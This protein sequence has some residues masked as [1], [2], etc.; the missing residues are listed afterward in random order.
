M[1]F[2][3]T[4]NTKKSQ[5]TQK[6][7]PFCATCDTP[8][9]GGFVKLLGNKSHHQIMKKLLL[10]LFIF[11]VIEGNAQNKLSFNNVDKN[12]YDYYNSGDWQSLI[13]IGEEAIKN[14]IDY[15][16]LN[17]RMGVANYMMKNYLLSLHYFEKAIYQNNTGL[18]DTIL[19]RLLMQDYIFTNNYTKAEYLK[20]YH[21]DSEIRTM[22]FTKKLSQIYLEGGISI[23]DNITQKV[24]EER[25]FYTFKQ[26]DQFRTMKYVNADIQGYIKQNLSYQFAFSGLQIDRYKFFK[27]FQDTLEQNYTINQSYIYGGI[28]YSLGN[29]YINPAINLPGYLSNELSIIGQDSITL[30]NIYDTVKVNKR[31]LVGGLRFGMKY[32]R[33]QVG[34]IASY[35][36]LKNNSQY[37]L[38]AEFIYFPNGNLNAYMSTNLVG[39]WENGAS[40][41]ILRQKFGMQFTPY[42]WGEMRLML[43]DLKNFNADN[44][45]YV[46]NTYDDLESIIDINLIFIVNKHIE[47]NFV[48]Q[49]LLKEN[50]LYSYPNAFNTKLETTNYYFQQIN[51]IGGI[52]WKF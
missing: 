4:N 38:G 15:Y 34:I 7:S 11:F 17:Y 43:G 6:S 37:Q 51:L 3:T 29:F 20:E 25:K 24:F 50:Y 21:P 16:Y 31:N 26:I 2:I 10:L 40:Y 41:L 13:L 19:V 1:D 42:M 49:H 52:K 30:R 33:M 46:Y 48:F 9:S 28:N 32:K 47:F 5:R 23:T 8:T 18:D 14:N 12:T 22:V 45:Y 27:D 44:G 39:K 35:S 36:N